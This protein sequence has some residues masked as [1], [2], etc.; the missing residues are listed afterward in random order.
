MVPKVTTILLL[1]P[2]SVAATFYL[3][4]WYTQGLAKLIYLREREAYKEAKL[5]PAQP[6]TPTEI[7]WLCRIRPTHYIDEFALDAE[8]KLDRL[9][10]LSKGPERI[11]R[12]IRQ[13]FFV[14]KIYSMEQL[15]DPDSFIGWFL[16]PRGQYPQLARWRANSF[17]LLTDQIARLAVLSGETHSRRSDPDQLLYGLGGPGYEMNRARL[18]ETYSQWDRVSLQQRK[19]NSI[20]FVPSQAVS[21]WKYFH[22]G[23]DNGPENRW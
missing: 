16:A 6:L 19:S 15:H 20:E 18:I 21:D 23:I 5:K 9:Q 2:I 10:R 13:V 11:R 12:W 8:S 3:G 1:A 7:K 14:L 22:S 17:P 4:K